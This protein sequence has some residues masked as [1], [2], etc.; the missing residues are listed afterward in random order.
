MFALILQKIVMAES[1]Y[2]LPKA[3]NSTSSKFF[4]QLGMFVWLC[5]I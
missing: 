1:E 2:K 3:L 4:D 5:I